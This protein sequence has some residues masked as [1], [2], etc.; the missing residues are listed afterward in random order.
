M[1]AVRVQAAATLSLLLCVI[2]LIATPAPC[3]HVLQVLR[4]LR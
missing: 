2:C 1:C 4:S 3:G